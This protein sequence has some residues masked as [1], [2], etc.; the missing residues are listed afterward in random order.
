[1]RG[2]VH[3]PRHA[4]DDGD[5]R[6]RQF[7]AQIFGYLAPVGGGVSRTH[8]RHC[9]S[10]GE[11]S[12]HEKSKGRVCDAGQPLRKLGL[13]SRHEAPAE[14]RELSFDLRHA[15]LQRGPDS[16][17]L[18]AGL[19]GIREERTRELTGGASTVRFC[20]DTGEAETWL[21]DGGLLFSYNRRLQGG[22]CGTG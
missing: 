2:G 16:R 13:P 21:G 20:D 10:L 11:D 1:V 7:P 3:P 9:V 19:L 18:H 17:L 15:T 14:F 5:T 12:T 8:E 6:T 4:R 22:L